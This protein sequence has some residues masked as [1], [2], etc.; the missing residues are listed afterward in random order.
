VQRVFV[1]REWIDGDRI[2][3]PE[4]ERHYLAGVLR[5]RAGDSFQAILDGEAEMN[6]VLEQASPRCVARI[7][8]REKV[9]EERGPSITLLQAV[10][11][12]PRMSWLVQKATE[13]GVSLLVGVVTER[14]VPRRGGAQERASRWRTIAREAAEQ[15]GA[16][17]L[18]RVEGALPYRQALAG[19][20]G[21]DLRLLLWE[22][23][24]PHL[25]DALARA[26][27]VERVCLA[28]GPEGGF[29]T[30]EVEAA[31]AAGFI[32]VSLGSR[33]LRSETA[34]IAA[35]AILRFALGG[36]E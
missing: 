25:R 21:Q 36:D 20:E 32:P 26:S 2:L 17:R 35:L 8:G 12:A 31:R 22:G 7:V 23:K 11:K 18:P 28:V 34:A 10:L 1:E 13:L 19:C 27:N 24:A 5:L 9:T 15:C 33:I 30:G 3:L 16:T 14:T 4:R 29:T 6:A